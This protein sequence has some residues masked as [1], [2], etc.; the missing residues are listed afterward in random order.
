MLYEVI[1][2]FDLAR[3]YGAI[4]AGYINDSFLTEG[5]CYAGGLRVMRQPFFETLISFIISANNN[6]GRIS[7]IIDTICEK[8]GEPLDGGFDFPTPGRLASL[9]PDEL[10]ASYNF[11]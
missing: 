4:Q 8:Y 9:A 10:K 6:V 11:V 3:D 1:T 7:R 5:I 2:Y